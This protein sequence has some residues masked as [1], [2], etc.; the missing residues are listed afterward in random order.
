MI[1]HSRWRSELVKI[2]LDELRS[3]AV[4]SR[5]AREA[6]GPRRLRRRLGRALI[7]A[8]SAL[9]G[10]QLDALAPAEDPA[11]YCNGAPA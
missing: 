6:A 5:L 1:D 7:A 4:A 9:L 3:Q 11:T 8:G 2:H 10:Q